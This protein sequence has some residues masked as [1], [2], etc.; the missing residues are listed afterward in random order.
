MADEDKADVILAFYGF[1][2]SLRDRRA[3][4]NFK[5][6]LDKFLK[7][8]VPGITS[9]KRRARLVCFLRLPMKSSLT[10][11]LRSQAEQRNLQKYNGHHG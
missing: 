10:Q 4:R 5:N 7:T 1:N 3:S 2:E 8:P 6:N 11:L 9:G